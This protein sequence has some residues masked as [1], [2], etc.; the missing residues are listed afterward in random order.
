ME[1]L[2]IFTEIRK[3]TWVG[4]KTEV[5]IVGAEDGRMTTHA[6]S[7]TFTK[8]WSANNNKHISAASLH[9]DFRGII[10]AVQMYKS[11][12]NVKLRT[13]ISWSYQRMRLNASSS[14]HVVISS[15]FVTLRHWKV[16][17]DQVILSSGIAVTHP[18][19]PPCSQHVRFVPLHSAGS[20]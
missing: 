1:I 9:R 14:E 6:S 4:V 13:I 19:M 7:S 17:E 11:L 15:D 18:A 16:S 5:W 3:K 20:S 12:Q 8:V 2:N 10:Q